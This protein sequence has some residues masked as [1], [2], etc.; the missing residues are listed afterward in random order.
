MKT[1]RRER[2]ADRHEITTIKGKAHSRASSSSQASPRKLSIPSHG[3]MASWAEHL[4]ISEP[5]GDLSW[6]DHNTEQKNPQTI[7]FVKYYSDLSLV[8]LKNRK[9]TQVSQ[10]KHL[11]VSTCTPKG[12]RTETL[13][14]LSFPPFLKS[15][16]YLP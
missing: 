14:L 2:G 7:S 16:Y 11:Y 4:S 8:C 12:R 15:Y 10:R 6:S 13:T 9:S 1:G 3:N 5:M